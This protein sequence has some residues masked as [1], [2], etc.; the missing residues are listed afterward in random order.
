MAESTKSVVFIDPNVADYQNIVNS[1]K[2][3]TLLFLLDG[4]RDGIQ[5]ITQ[6][7]SGLRD[8]DS[9]QI[10]SQGAEGS[11]SLGSTVLNS[12][13]LS[14][15][16]SQ[17]QQWGQSLTATGDI[18]LYGS[19][20]A[21]GLA[22]K[23]F[24]QQISQ[25]TGADVAA[26]DDLTGNTASGGDWVLEY[27]TGLIEASPALEIAPIISNGNSQDTVGKYTP[28]PPAYASNKLIVKFKDGINTTQANEIKNTLG[29]AKTETIKLTGAQIWTLSGKT[30]VE[31]ALATHKNN[32]IFQYIEPDYIV[33]K[34]VTFPNDPSFNQLWGL[35]NTGQ[36]GGT[37]DADIDAPEAWDIQTGN[38]NLVI[39]V[40]DTGV[41]Y[42]HP[43][44]VG[45][46]WTNP[47]EIA[48]D[49]IDN[50]NN[51]YIDDIRGWDFAYN[52]NNPSDV[53]GHGTHVSGTIAGKGNNGVG[54]TGVAW[55]AKIMP[56]KFLDDTGSGSTS[57]A[58]LAINYA[59]AKG[60][61]ITNNSWGGGGYSQ[62]LYD[63]I[64]A[65][66]QAG[67]L[68]IAAA[69]NSSA[70]ADINPMYPAA[71]NLANIISVASTTN[72]D[73]LSSF[74]NYGLTSVDLG[75]PG[76]SIYSTLPNNSYGTLSGT[77]MASPHV[78]GAAALVWS[79]NPTWTAQQVK[80]TLMNTGDSIAALAGKTVSGKRL[81]VF[82][83]L[84]A[85]NLPSVTVSVSPATVQEDGA[86]N[87][88]Y[89]FTRTNLN[90]SSPLTVNFGASGIAN[91]APVGSDPADYNVLTG[92]AVT[93]NPTTKLGT[94]T[95]AA[96]ATTATVVVDPIADTLAENQNETVNITVNSGT[97]YIG[98][99][100][101]AATGTIVNEEPFVNLFYDSFANNNAGWTLGTEWGIGSAKT[102]TGHVY[103]NP[104]P[105]TDN[106]ATADNGVAGVVIG[107]NA[108]TSLHNYYYL[109]SPVI[110][111]NTSGNVFFEYYRW[112]NSDY[113]PYMQNTVDIYN[114]S[115]WVNLWSSGGSP[116][117]QDNSWNLNTFNISAYK[118][119]STQ[120]RFGFNVGSTGVFTVSSWNI[121]DFKIYTDSSPSL[122]VITVVANDASAGEPAN[123]GQ[124]TLTRT[125][126]TTSSLTVNVALTGT[127]TNG[128]DYTTI[129][130]TVT[131]A[132][133]SSTALVNLNVTDD[134]LV[135]GAETAILTVTSGTGYTVGTSASATVNIADNDL[136]S[137]NLS[138]NQ[139]VVEGNTSPQNVTYT[140]TLSSAST[141]T[142]TVQY[143]TVGNT[144]IAGSDYTTTS[145]TLTF[146]PGVTSQVINIPILN[147]DLNEADETF[148]LTLS[149][150]TNA[151][152]GTT[153]TVTTTITDTL[154]ADVTTTLPAGV[155]NLTLTGTAAINGTGNAGNNV[156]TG[157]SANNSLTGGAGNDTLNG[158][159][160]I[161]ALI[162]GL[163]DDAYIVDS[164]T[165]II[166]ENANEGTD[167]IQSSVTFSISAITNIENLTLTGTAAINGTGNAGNNVLTG[168]S[169]NNTLNAGA[170]NDTLDGGAG[171]DA[172]IGGLGN[173][174]YI[175]DSATDIITENAGGGTD[176]IQSS[177][178]FNIVTRT[179]IENLTLT[180]AAAINGTGNA[181][182]NVLIGNSAN[183]ILNGGAGNDTLDGG[184]GID[185]L[186]GSLGNDVYSVDSTTDIITENAGGGTD[187]IQSSVTFSIAT[188]TNIENLTL[189]GTDAINGTGN[190]GNNV[191]TG[192]SANNSLDGAA[193]IDTLI[194]GDGN[195]TYYVDN[196]G[197]TITENANQGTDTVYSTTNYTLS[198]NI[199][200]L[201]LTGSDAINGT[202]NAGN[203]V[204]TGSSADN[205]LDGA[206][207]NDT[208]NG[209][210]GIDTLIGGLG[211]DAYIVD[212]TTD[213]ITENA[214]EGT[215]TIS[216]SVTYS[217]AA[218]ANVENLTLGGTEAINGTGNAA[219][220]VLTGNAA[221]NTLDGASGNDTLDGGGGIDILIGGDGNDTYYVDTTD[222]TI[223]ENANEGTDTVYTT[224][225]YALLE[226][227]ENLTLTGTAA[228]GTGNDGNNVITGNELDNILDGGAGIDTL[229][230]GDGN[231]T[232]YVDDSSDIITENANEGTDT[233]YSTTNY[234]LSANIENLTLTG[235]AAINGTGNAGNNVITGNELDNILDGG[236]GI[237]TLIGGDGN[238][239]YYV[240]NSSDIITENANEGTDTVYSTTNYTLSANIENLTLTG[241]AANGTGNAG[242]NTLTGN[243]GNNILTGNIGN[244][245]LHG[246]AGNDTLHGGA[247]IDTLI[248]G[249]GNDVYIVDT[250]TDTITELSGEGT[251]TIESSVTFTI[252]TL[253]NIENLTLTGTAAINGTG[254]SGNNT[255]TGNTGN[256]TLHGGTGVDTLIGGTGNDIYVVDTT[257]DTITENANEGTDTIQS[258][259]TFT[260][261]SLTN[262]ENLTLTG[263]AAIN[264][265]GNAGNNTLTGNT[266]NNILVGG[267]GN[268]LLTGGTGKD[269]LTGGV[270]VDRF[271]YRNLADSVFNNNSFDVITDFNA[272]ADRFVVTTARSAFNNVGTVATLDAAGIAVLLNTTTFAANSAAQFSFGSRTFVAIN[273][274]TAG[275]S[276]TA[277]AIVELTGFTGTLGLNN[278]T[279]T[280]V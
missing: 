197:D 164:N 221:D 46:I 227:L 223:T 185:T 235:T 35:H 53:D 222:D 160:G 201:T 68:F 254:N 260:I 199:E 147:D 275:F 106:T 132:A 82:N 66:G 72:T 96:N 17:L 15:Y 74:S 80:N 150:P 42:N 49:G 212:T 183:N 268:D 70:N 33:T 220:N 37:P 238:D 179:N 116:G 141:E 130:T 176:T 41:D 112:L 142:V 65:A 126:L 175:V 120:I 145:G 249:L 107:G 140:V 90:L 213:T 93:F 71:Y 189:T 216:T 9:L 86:T 14:S 114:G 67:A 123:P 241:T 77:S 225:D 44:L 18:L 137:I 278:F 252:A 186:I 181:G 47:G 230:G 178:T 136:P 57:N 88:V 52:D 236:A 23:T 233:V 148:T 202:G 36:S 115:S 30:S 149:S 231:D 129:P 119:A 152:L 144:A 26:S 274:A 257:T 184:A 261:A 207:G 12:A 62:A 22:G 131:F 158:G 99:S 267:D 56:L 174:V 276:A 180:G 54:V 43:D 24:V 208:L 61:K 128:T 110:N 187:T 244:N 203:N 251:D 200:D 48:N 198:A 75:A 83:A 118:S 153:T 262:I 226:N 229:I 10:I 219:N 258:S 101:G 170:G 271:D 85:A 97:G 250:T 87:L 92:S 191:I 28:N 155:E 79:Q 253:A 134:T 204:I 273:N 169:A 69:G 19:N 194:G 168:N 6:N 159:A 171:I 100:P 269:T 209:G 165:D 237:D 1:V 25:L 127:A 263:T 173:D 218:L 255:L 138:A 210:A 217:L 98:G 117:V 5:Q 45:N 161:D 3:G 196:T 188:L 40:L 51:G 166:T 89:T 29:V 32:P 64:N 248:G 163:G 264:G 38:P 177:V 228:N 50:D 27:T 146:A 111:T 60:V 266:G 256:N 21:Q 246:G 154:T 247:G 215:D 84:A 63:A 190:A 113:T 102:S 13:N 11:L 73:S 76:S 59:T 125:G 139:T 20:V 270:G 234:T 239:T 2:P 242:N 108:S 182:N 272:T 156:L 58:I 95:F 280:L 214:N 240:D 55:N 259:V 105:G 104:D 143:A 4:N 109:T 122:P 34:A 16:T 265:T 91:A 162:G 94:V 193:G 78:A 31:T 279:T 245:T 211:D 205:I 133:G 81:N 192:N 121:D 151:N 224:T 135:E 103:G 157:N 195:D 124:Y 172:L 7:L 206:S 39:G 8:I 243:T 232:Y 277:D 167:T